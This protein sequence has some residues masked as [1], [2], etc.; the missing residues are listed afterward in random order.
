MHR[1]EHGPASS[2]LGMKELHLQHFDYARKTEAEVVEIKCLD[3]FGQNL[4]IVD[5]LMIKID[6]QGYEDKVIEG[7]KNIISRAKLVIIE[8]SFEEL[9]EGQPLF[10]DI[11]LQMREL[12]FR[13]NG[14][15][16]QVKSQQDRRVLQENSVYLKI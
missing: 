8:S 11:Y 9:Y 3:D 1:N 10:D 12:G 2:L 6:V 4:H 7:G 13:Y 14:D 5:P 15:N 16:H